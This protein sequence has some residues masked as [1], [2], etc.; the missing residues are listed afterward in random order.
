[1]RSPERVDSLVLITRDRPAAL[2]RA[3][4]SYARSLT[5]EA[6]VKPCVQMKVFD[7]SRDPDVASRNKRLCDRA[8]RRYGIN[9]SYVGFAQRAGMATALVRNGCPPAVARFAVLG[10]GL[11]VGANRNAVL[12]ET[13]GEM[14]ISADDDTECISAN[15][16]TGA[17]P[18]WLDRSG[19][20]DADPAY[21]CTLDTFPTRRALLQSRVFAA[22]PP[23]STSAS[24]LGW[25]TAEIFP[26]GSGCGSTNAGRR[27]VLTLPGLAGD[28][29]WKHPGLYLW[30]SGPSYR[31]LTSSPAHYQQAMSS[32]EVIRCV[33]R[34]TI[35][36]ELSNMTGACFGFDNRGALP[37]FPPIGRGQD[38]IFGMLL[39]RSRPDA[40]IAHLPHAVLHSPIEP[41]TFTAADVCGVGAGVDLCTVLAACL[42]GCSPGTG[43][44][45][46]ADALSA[47]AAAPEPDADQ[48]LREAVIAFTRRRL[49]R[50]HT[51]WIARRRFEPWRR[52]VSSVVRAWTLA[53]REPSYHL[54]VEF[55]K[56]ASYADA[57][58]AT[59]RF[60][61]RYATLLRQWCDVIDL[62]RR[63][64]SA[65]LNAATA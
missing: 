54:P 4:D 38:V 64:K 9:I 2:R 47:I 33:R 53:V 5:L 48:R 12:L 25:S 18:R 43:L 19:R 16:E 65:G 59:V 13:Q 11:T 3:L 31:R 23:A 24:W 63:L 44:S 50:L 1:M 42:C 10:S 15:M 14:A 35:T 27:V 45:A 7:D 49:E 22:T 55:S 32:R 61:D 62:Y 34:P 6:S 46:A 56:A 52:D 29:G 30:L 28:C 20:F 51:G 57:R 17:S 58:R 40:A 36:P 60:L 21:P 26:D 37:P 41:R 8:S 39:A